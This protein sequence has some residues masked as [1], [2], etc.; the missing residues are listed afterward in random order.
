MKKILHIFSLISLLVTLALEILPNGAALTFAPKPD[1]RIVKTYSYFSN[2]PFGYAHF[3]PLITAILTV[4]IIILTVISMLIYFKSQKLLTAT[5][6]CT[7]IAFTLSL[8]SAIPVG[9]AIGAIIIV[10]LLISLV[11]QAIYKGMIW[12]QNK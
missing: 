8:I 7:F 1:T 6:A 3:S 9:T 11:L 12:N 5:L 10:L 2:I 4:V